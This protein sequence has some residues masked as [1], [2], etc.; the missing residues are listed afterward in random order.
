MSFE[1]PSNEK[2]KDLL[3]N[4]KT[5]AVVGLSDKPYRTSFQVSEAMQ[6]AG[7]KIIPV[8]PEIEEALGEKAV[9][10]LS[11][12][13]EPVDIVNVFRRSEY[14]PE[15]AEE[16]KKIQPKAFW[17]QQ[18]VYHEGAQELLKDSSM[19]VI[20]DLCIKVAHAIYR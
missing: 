5:I 4:S 16:T 7:Y 8:N 14:L 10:S 9:P 6:R 20:M 18:G 15:V 17:A 13:R 3:A 12:I 11:D 19:L 1:N 2:V